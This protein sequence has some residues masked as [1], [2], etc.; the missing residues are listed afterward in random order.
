[1][2]LAAALLC[3]ALLPACAIVR[4]QVGTQV[5][6]IEGLE[7]GVTTR[8]QALAQLGPPRLVRRQFDGELYTWR[9]LRGR[10]RSIAILP[11][12]VRLFFWEDARML[13]DDVTL[14]FNREGVLLAVG[15]RLETAEREAGSDAV[16]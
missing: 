5:P 1:M 12:F 10:S 13:R 6:G 16:D 2:R 4:I 3:L 8:E 7:V 14:L 15:R 9:T 11:I